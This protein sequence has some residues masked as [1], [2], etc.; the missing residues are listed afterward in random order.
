MLYHG[1]EYRNKY[2]SAVSTKE[3]CIKRNNSE[4]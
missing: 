2:E 4:L 3:A 1:E